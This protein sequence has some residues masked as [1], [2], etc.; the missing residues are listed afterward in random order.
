[1]MELDHI[2]PPPTAFYFN[3]HFIGPMPIMDMAF[4][5]VSGMTM[6][7]ETQEID[8]GGGHKRRIPGQMK[9]GN[10]VCKRPLKPV[11]MSTLSVWT[12]VTMMGGTES[13]VLTSDV[14]VTLLSPIGTP[15]C[16]WYISGAYPVKWD[17]AGFDSK[18]NDIALETIEFAYD[19]VTRV[20]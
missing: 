11:G 1:M 4:L 10:L 3:V 14:M 15:E 8:E 19:T 5:E 6:E 12:S 2:I 7:M 18:K 17:I 20:L 9:H 13:D 16:G